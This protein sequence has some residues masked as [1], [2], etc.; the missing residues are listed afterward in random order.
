MKSR[1]TTEEFIQKANLRHNNK[2]NYNNTNYVFNK[3]KV[4]I[5][6]PNHGDF[7]QAPVKHL[8]GRG[9]PKCKTDKIRNLFR[10]NK[11]SFIQ[12][13]KSVHGD[14]YNYSQVEYITNWKKVTII[15]PDHGNFEQSPNA[16]LSQKQGCPSCGGT[17]KLISEEFI[18]CASE[19]HNNSYDYSKVIYK[20]NKKKVIVTCLKH[21]DFFVTPNNHI[22]KKSGCPICKASKGEL[23]LANVLNKLGIKF[24]S[25]F[26][27]P[28][29]SYNF[30]Y[31]FYLP[32]L[33]LLIEYHG[34]QHFKPVDFFGG[35]EALLDR[36][37][38]DIFKRSLALDLGFKFLELNYKQL[39]RLGKEEFENKFIHKL[40]DIKLRSLK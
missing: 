12:K 39:K 30:R 27:I 29:Q 26:I 17:K 8:F 5:T 38:K 13:A 40:N 18:K 35:K 6:C 33:N 14:R 9:C 20:G 2:Y 37:K 7:Y 4:I 1:L 32:D 16:H 34:I 25:Q 28:N 24:I 3:Q 22:A 23:L 36:Q 11:E 19:T 15:C 31:D 21:G 10:S